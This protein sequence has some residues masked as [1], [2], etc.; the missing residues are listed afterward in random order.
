MKQILKERQDLKNKIDQ[1]TAEMIVLK[2][3]KSEIDLQV[4][5]ELEKQEMKS[6]KYNDETVSIGIRHGFI[7]QDEAKAISIIPKK[8]RSS[9]Y[10]LNKLMFS[11]AVK[12]YKKQ[13][14][15][16]PQGIEEVETKYL[17]VR[18]NKNK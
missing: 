10:Q 15:K 6:V 16:I 11:N 18:I 4:I 12:E 2:E 5:N 14:S 17:S 9:Y 8:E 1:L 7:I 13:T 3:K